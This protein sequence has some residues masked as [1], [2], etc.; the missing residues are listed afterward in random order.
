MSRKLARIIATL[1]AVG[2]SGGVAVAAGVPALENL[3]ARPAIVSPG[4]LRNGVLAT[5]RAGARIVAVGD[6]GTV[7]LSD[8]DGASFRQARQV[9]TRATLTSVCFN[10]DGRTGWAAGHWGVILGTVDGGETWQLRRQDLTV[11]RPLFVLHFT[12][13]TEGY[14]AGLWSL[15]L[16]TR[17]AGRTWAPVPLAAA[18]TEGQFSKTQRNLLGTF[19]SRRGTLFIAAEQGAVYRS[20]DR[21]AS[22]ELIRTGAGG[23]LW[24]GIGLRSGTVLVA[25]LGGSIYRSV[26]DGRSWHAVDSGT[27]SSVT[28]I[29]ELPD[30]TLVAVGLDGL[31]LRSRDDGQS[32]TASYDP[33]RVSLTAVTAAESGKVVAFSVQGPRKLP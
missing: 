13:A 3:A 1:A 25:G 24:T 7:L 26:D 31:A 20:Q 10:A 21:G 8:D 18:E 23:S 9:P 5:T 17:D 12:S 15:F 28:D 11:D 6:R 19:E 32:F 27:H 16:R 14:A 33:E 29:T 22:W 2:F 4:V 30:G